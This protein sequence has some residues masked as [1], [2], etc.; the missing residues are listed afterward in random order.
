M[1]ASIVLRRQTTVVAERQ[2]DPRH[3]PP[4]TLRAACKLKFLHKN[5]KA[6]HLATLYRWAVRGIRGVKLE[7]L[8]IGGSM[9]TSENSLL[10]FIR[11]LSRN[12]SALPAAPTAARHAAV[13]WAE[14][15]LDGAGI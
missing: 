13:D 14:A 1:A 11:A 15:E 5:G 4:L 8:V 7:T 10:R 6:P 3:E 2:F 9:V 12:E